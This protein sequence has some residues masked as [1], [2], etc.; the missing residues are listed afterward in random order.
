MLISAKQH[1]A[2]QRNAQH[3][4]GPKTPE[5]KAAVRLNALTYGL[6]AREI[7]LDDEDP[8]EYKQL[9]AELEAEWQP[10]TRTER[11]H[12]EQM[13]TSQWWLARLAKRER[14]VYAFEPSNLKPAM[15]ECIFALRA[16][17][18]RSFSNALRELRQSRRERQTRPAQPS[19]TTHTAAPAPPQVQKP[20]QPH[21]P[22]PGYVMS[23]GG[24]AHPAFF[25]PAAPDTR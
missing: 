5:G 20:A 1:H 22:P 8:E 10:R 16:R 14:S 21:A 24:A 2:N 9:W 15:L 17:L 19:Q 25:S 11:L 12:L 23:D 7:L 6:R 3:S 13:A 4:T 18:E